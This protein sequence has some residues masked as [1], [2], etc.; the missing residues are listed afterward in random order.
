MNDTEYPQAVPHSNR[1]A[2]CACGALRLT[3]AGAPLR[4]HACACRQCQIASG[5]AFT[6]TAFYPETALLACE[7]EYRTFRRTARSG[8]WQEGCFCPTCGGNVFSRHQGWPGVIGIA[9][10]CFGDAGFERPSE[11]LWCSERHEWLVL[12]KDIGMVEMQ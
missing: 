5:T 10:G 12:S 3:V 9:V 4:V 8:N 1:I 6:Y 11:L 2:T 7:G